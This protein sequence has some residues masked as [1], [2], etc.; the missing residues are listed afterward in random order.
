MAV[1]HLGEAMTKDMD[2][3]AEFFASGR[4]LER[5]NSIAASGLTNRTSSSPLTIRPSKKLRS[6]SSNRWRH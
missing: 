4:R 2:T 5:S 3:E 1:E 6:R